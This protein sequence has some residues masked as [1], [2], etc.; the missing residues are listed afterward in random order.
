MS[1]SLIGK[2]GASL[3]VGRTARRSVAKPRVR[4]PSAEQPP[5][6]VSTSSDDGQISFHLVPRERV[7][8]VERRRVLPGSEVLVQTVRFEDDC[9]FVRW[10]DI[11]E[12]QFEYPLLFA[13]LKR[14]ARA[15][16]AD[17]S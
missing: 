1:H 4:F 11:D 6:T 2:A 10:C 12:L 17:E 16:F 3:T 14:N 7:V 13:N 15:L 5:G 8:L 9:S